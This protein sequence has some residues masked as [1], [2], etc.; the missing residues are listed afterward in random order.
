MTGSGPGQGWGGMELFNGH[1]YC[2][3]WS[4]EGDQVKGGVGWNFLMATDTA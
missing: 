1:I 4:Q 3:A 2:L